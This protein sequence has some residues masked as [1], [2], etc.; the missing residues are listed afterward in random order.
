MQL[1]NP[2]T[3]PP[4]AAR[5]LVEFLASSAVI[6]GSPSVEEVLSATIALARDVFSAD[7]YALWR[8]DRDGAW[9]MARAFGISEQFASRVIPAA[10]GGT[11]PRTV[12]FS[13]PLL[14]TDVAAAPM[15]TEMRDAYASEGIASMIVF[16]LS[17]R[18]ER[19]G[20]LVFYSRERRDYAPSDVQVGTA[21]ANLAGAALTTAE[22]YEEQQHAREAADH[23]RERAV[24]LAQASSALSASLDY[25]ATLRA[26]ARLAVPTIADWCAVDILDQQGGLQRLAV[27]HVNP[28]KVEIALQLQKR[29]PPDPNAAGGVHQVIRTGEPVLVPRIPA[30][31]L[32]RAAHD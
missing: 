9:R 29:Y 20:T 5:R 22:L 6:L 19:L 23:A 13:E 32:D 8:A 28:E 27:A 16:P 31:L 26:V 7:G 21:L 12:P 24:F 14:V 1:D 4:D 3:V 10:S 30:D 17:V 11:G 15:V 18:G 25:E 2:D